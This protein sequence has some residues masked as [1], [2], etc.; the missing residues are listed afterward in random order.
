[1]ISLGGSLGGGENM[2]NAGVTFKLGQHNHV[3]TTR[4]AM[5]KEI[6][7]LKALVNQQYGEMQQMKQMV[8]QLA[9]KTALS[10]DTSALF[11]DIPRTTGPMSM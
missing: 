1:M 11:P 7:A 5:A 2:I 9:G 8:N 10:V 3:S 4:V 6:K